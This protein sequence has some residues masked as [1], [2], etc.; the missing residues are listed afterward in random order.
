V[1]LLAVA[2]LA[3]APG[4]THADVPGV[5]VMQ[6][7]STRGLANAVGIGIALST[8]GVIICEYFAIT[9]VL[10]AITRVQMRPIAIALGVLMIAVAPFTLID[11]EGFY[12]SLSEPSLVALWLSQLVV[13]LVFPRFARRHG[14]RALPA[15]TMSLFAGGLA[16]YGLWTALQ[17]AS[18]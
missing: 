12:N 3:A 1:I 16:V 18:S 8:A 14:Q 10:H 11:P 7:F 9:R 17:Q 13:F 15:W 6:L 5:T 2:P 4:L